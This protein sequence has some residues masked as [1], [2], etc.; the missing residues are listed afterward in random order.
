[1][2]RISRTV[3]LGEDGRSQACAARGDGETIA[4]L[5]A[6]QDVACHRVTGLMDEVVEK[7]H[8][9]APE[10]SV[11]MLSPASAS[12]DQYDNYSHRGDQFVAAVEAL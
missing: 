8:E 4:R 10:G 1:M 12:F 9:I 3:L 7:A 5:C 11:V 6:E 2:V